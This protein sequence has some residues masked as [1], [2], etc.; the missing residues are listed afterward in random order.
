[1]HVALRWGETPRTATLTVYGPEEAPPLPE[2]PS[3][4]GADWYPL[5]MARELDD[6]LLRLRFN[7]PEIGLVLVETRGDPAVALALD[8]QLAARKDDWFVNEVLLNLKRVLK[9]Y[10]L[11][12]KSFFALAGEGSCF[13]GALFELALGADRIY[14]LEAEG[15]RLGLSELNGGLLPMSNGLSRLETR[16]LGDEGRAARL[17]AEPR[18][19]E[20]PAANEEGLVTELVDELD[21]EDDLRMAIEERASLSP[22]ALTGME[23][24]L[25]FAGPE[26]LETKIF[27]RLS[28]WQNW[29]FQRPNAVGPRGALTLYGQPQ[30]AEF[31]WSRT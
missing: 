22:D 10:D 25:R 14:M 16:F 3:R 2:D 29:I 5:R 7:H 17:A 19:F 13:A 6:A 27:G 26:T 11:T 4:L 28:A 8:A 24:N 20:G 30:Q 15:V 18:L 9:R 1:R 12:A 23:A 31:D 21:W